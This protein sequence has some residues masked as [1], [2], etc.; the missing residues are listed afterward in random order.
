MKKKAVI[1]AIDKIVSKYIEEQL[2]SLF[3]DL[4]D[5]DA[6]SLE[7]GISG[8]IACDICI[9]PIEDDIFNIAEK[10]MPG[11]KFLSVKRTLLKEGWKKIEAIPYGTRVLLVNSSMKLSIEAISFLLEMGANHIDYI[12][13]SPGVD[14][15]P[16]DIKVAVTPNEV[17]LVP[18]DI[19]EII[20]IGDRVIDSTTLFDILTS[21]K[22]LNN[23][24]KARI[25]DYITTT[26]SKGSSVLNFFNQFI[27]EKDFISDIVNASDY[28]VIACDADNRIIYQSKIE[29]SISKE[30]LY[31]I[32][33]DQYFNN[34]DIIRP[35]EIYYEIFDIKGKEYFV[36]KMDRFKDG[37]LIAKIY[38]IV[39]C[40][41]LENVVNSYKKHLKLNLGKARYTF[42]DIV[43]NSQAIKKVKKI[44]STAAK[45]NLDILI[46]G[47]TG[48]GKELFA[49]SIHN[50]SMRK[51]GPFIAFN[52]A[53]ISSNLLESEL[54]GYEEGAFTGAKKGGKKG[55]IEAADDGTLF[56]DEIGEISKEAQV[57]LLRVLQEREVVKVGGITRIPIN[58]RVIAATNHDL[59]EL[60]RNNEFRKDL[61]YRLNVVSIKIPPLRERKEDI[62]MLISSF[63][64]NRNT[65]LKFNED[66]L[67]VFQSYDW[68]G[69][70]RELLN[71]V[72]YMLGMTEEMSVDELPNNIKRGVDVSTRNES[73]PSILGDYR[74]KEKLSI[75]RVINEFNRRGKKIGRRAISD[76]LRKIDIIIS[77]NE[78]RSLLNELK[79]SGLVE[80]HKG[81][82]GTVVTTKGKE[83]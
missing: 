35:G 1:I 28:I 21:L 68:P 19:D 56:L 10:F 48:T 7:E 49:N 6:Y 69:N 59:H 80:V 47:E 15:F 39:K 38:A 57:K 18:Y 11:T 65:K 9:Y 83:L 33:I 12:P 77:E 60:V 50:E 43:G 78:V 75:I 22:L 42:E 73:Y 16:K 58:I 25:G 66:V 62:V 51:N 52:C 72:E 5:F 27:A 82:A 54:F 64:K 20:N 37:E 70:V 81:R 71:C 76:E 29:S 14:T 4:I 31:G 36:N 3:D 34:T 63:L 24:T 41:D 23:E 26:I 2:N 32:R 17:E 55:L 79:E 74:Q 40:K 8:K 44:A 13:Y 53:A 67:N 45:T 46:E 30:I 61:Y